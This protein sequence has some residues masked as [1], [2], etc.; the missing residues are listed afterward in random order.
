M[1]IFSSPVVRRCLFAMLALCLVLE[2]LFAPYDMNADS[3]SYLDL[4][5]LIHAHQW[6]WVVNAYWHP[7]YPALLLV[8]RMVLGNSV[9]HELLAARL[10]NLAIT[11]L[12]FLA[13]RFALRSTLELRQSQ[14]SGAGRT[15]SEP[16]QVGTL[17]MAAAGI[18]LISV[19]RELTLRSVRPDV[20]L[21]ALLISGG[22]FLM[23]AGARR[24][25]GSFA[26]LGVCFGLG[27]LVKSIAFPIFLVALLLLFAVAG[28]VKSAVKGV[29]VA[30][31]IFA[32]LAGPYIGALSRQKGRFSAGDSGGLNYAWFVDGAD[33]FELQ[34]DD[35]SRYGLALGQLK[36]TSVQLLKSPPVY[37]FGGMPGTEPQWLD[38]SYWDDGLKPRFNLNAQVRETVSGL[39]IVV[40]YFVL[41]PQYALL[42]G[43][44]AM[45][46][47]RWRK[48]D[49]GRR[50]AG[51]VLLLGLA[52]VGLYL[53]VYTEPRYIANAII[54]ACCVLLALMRLPKSAFGQDAAA[55]CAALFLIM[56]LCN[57]FTDSLQNM[58][59]EKRVEGRAIGAYNRATF[60]AGESLASAPG[61]APGD[62][63]ACL[64]EAAC[65]D[66]SY[67]AR[68]AQ[69]KIRTEIFADKD[70]PLA[71]WQKADKAAT[72]DVVRSTGAKAIVANFGQDVPGGE[73]RRLGSDG[74]FVLYL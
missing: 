59:A 24:D 17:D 63:V 25:V 72:L 23:R 39:M 42:F 58:S 44:L 51:P 6:H 36:H 19:M 55:L 47:G 74:F 66:D 3:V 46:G 13:V 9:R 11:G 52:Q 45:L 53:V 2:A 62:T 32:A 48:S 61:I 38:P 4:S 73:W 49:F 70:S 69:V 33:R 67:W 60:T 40:Q 54:L 30:G 15:G 10:L 21:A 37:F 5:D 71:V 29:V 43:A 7:V 14:D 50:G 22:A 27:F 26:G 68:L 34:K 35:P 28:S 31:L 18:V 8:S 12:L 57:S 41:R 56:L 65:R 16:L 20:L 1:Q 64:G